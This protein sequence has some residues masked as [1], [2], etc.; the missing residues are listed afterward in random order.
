[1]PISPTSGRHFDELHE[2]S[3]DP[4]RVFDGWYEVR[5]RRILLAS[6][7][8]ERLGRVLEI[9]CSVGAVT[10]ELAARADAVIALDVAQSAVERARVTTAACSNVDIRV[11][12]IRE[13]LPS[14]A[15]DTVVVSEVAY[16]L[17]EQEWADVLDDIDLALTESGVVALCHWKPVEPDFGSNAERVHAQAIDRLSARVV[18]HHDE[19]D[20]V[21]DVLSR[22][23][24]SVAEREGLR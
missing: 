14:G 18:A 21:I 1:M 2:R 4:W 13:G 23:V 15:F 19:P 5:K 24:R 7:P 16:Y 8:D 11:A 9:G 3:D 17:D 6:L 12:D 22:D 20:F 10:V